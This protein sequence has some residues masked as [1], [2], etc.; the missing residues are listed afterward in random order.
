ME[1]LSDSLA[2]S[3]Q[4]SNNPNDVSSPHPRLSEYKIK[5]SNVPDQE[6][7]R[8]RILEEQK[9]RRHDRVNFARR[10]VEED[11]MEI[12]EDQPKKKTSNWKTAKNPFKNQLMMSEWLVDLPANFEQEW[13]MVIS[14]IGKRCLVVASR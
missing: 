4:I 11:D 14:P 13:V 2:S 6:T 1:E 5:P 10:L 3:F 9:S 12:V 8:K 7:R